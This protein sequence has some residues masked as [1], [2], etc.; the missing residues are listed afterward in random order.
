MSRIG[1][2]DQRCT[3]DD[4]IAFYHDRH[5]ETWDEQIVSDAS[6][7]DFD[8]DAI[9]YYRQLRRDVDSQAEEL[10]WNRDDLLEALSA[11]K[12][13]EGSLRPTVAGILLFGSTKALRRL[14]PMHRIDYIRVPGLRWVKDPDRRFETIEIRAPLIRAIVRARS[15]ILD[16][17]PKAFSLP[18]GEVQGKDIPLLPDRVIREVVAN[19]V[20]HR[21]YRVHGSIQIIRYSNRLE[22]RNPGYSIK[23]EE[24][25]GQPGSETRNPKIAAVLHDI[26]FAETKG[27]GIRVM[28]ELMDERGLTPPLFQSDRTGNSFFAMLLFHH[29]LSQ[30]DVDWLGTFDSHNLSE[31]EMKAMISAREVGAI[32]NSTYRDI[33]RETDTLS[34][35]KHLR[36]LC[37]CGLLEKRGNGPATYYVPT[38]VT[39]DNWL[40]IV[41]AS[42]AVKKSQQL[43]GKSQEL[44]TKKQEL[45]SKSQEF[46]TKKQELGADFRPPETRLEELPLEIAGQIEAQGKKGNPAEMLNL[47]LK[48]LEGR[49]LSAAELAK[50]LERT[51]DYVRRNYLRP[52]IESGRVRTSNPANPTDPGLTYTATSNRDDPQ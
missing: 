12:R 42:E 9:E 44:L 35:S 49:S 48:I 2:T 36:K 25:L 22:I 30:E 39:L 41:V 50:Y 40:K 10:T 26:K 28:R 37:D 23:A 29:F 7:A 24:R 21:D 52:L 8:D 46:P 47:V 32:D 19:A 15:A 4:L 20:M 27:S 1:S 18:A 34:A 13:R 51:P 11:V 6:M 38:D 33:N 3:E 17:L 5:D 45:D 14:F 16:D 31:D 43:D